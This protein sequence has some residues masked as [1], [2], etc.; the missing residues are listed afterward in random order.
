MMLMFPQEHLTLVNTCSPPAAMRVY[1]GLSVPVWMPCVVVWIALFCTKILMN[2]AIQTNFGYP[3]FLSWRQFIAAVDTH[4][5]RGPHVQLIWLPQSMITHCRELS[6][7]K[8]F[9]FRRS[10]HIV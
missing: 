10:L 8:L 4:S 9:Q 7:L 1:I 5:H 6:S 3:L 2:T